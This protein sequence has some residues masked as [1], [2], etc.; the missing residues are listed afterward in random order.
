LGGGE[1]TRN[2]KNSC[3]KQKWSKLL[4]GRMGGKDQNKERG[5]KRYARGRGQKKAGFAKDFLGGEV[6]GKK[7]VDFLGRHRKGP[8]P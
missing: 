7:K 5:K 8:G 2:G 3:E 4:T 1:A 6:R